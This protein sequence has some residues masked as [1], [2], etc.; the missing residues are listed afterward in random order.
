MTENEITENGITEHT[1]FSGNYYE[2]TVKD[3]AEHGKICILDMD[4][5]VHVTFLFLVLPVFPSRKLNSSD[6][7]MIRGITQRVEQVKKTDLDARYLYLF[8]PSLEELER[9]LE[10][11]GTDS[12]DSIKR[13]LERAKE[14]MEVSKTEGIYDRIVVNRDVSTAYNELE[15]FIFEGQM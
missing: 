8:P 12:K 9:R 6:A 4:M 5:E 3:A 7:N 2:T 10:G 13:K 11:R 1:Q 14:E 15:E